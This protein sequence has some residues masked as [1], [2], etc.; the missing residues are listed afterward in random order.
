MDANER[1]L[2]YYYG[3]GAT[4]QGWIQ[5]IFITRKKG[6]NTYFLNLTDRPV[7]AEKIERDIE[8]GT[9]QELPIPHLI[10]QGQAVWITPN[11][12]IYIANA[13]NHKGGEQ[14]LVFQDN[15]LSLYDTV[16]YVVKSNFDVLGMS[17]EPYFGHDSWKILVSI[18]VKYI[19]IRLIKE[20]NFGNVG[21]AFAKLEDR[22]SSSFRMLLNEYSMSYTFGRLEFTNK[23]GKPE[24]WE[25]D[26]VDD[27]WAQYLMMSESFDLSSIE[28]RIEEY[29]YDSE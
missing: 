8:N 1:I 15:I 10:K 7:L 20:S 23:K 5:T 6:G 18:L 12:S 27:S 21:Y 17:L 14:I 26:I 11:Q 22:Y 25:I 2:T 29:D 16:D 9:L 3:R 13:K 28:T 4:A 24:R 19:N